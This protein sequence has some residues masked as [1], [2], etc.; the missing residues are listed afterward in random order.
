[1]FLNRNTPSVRE[2]RVLGG[3]WALTL[4][5]AACV[6][7]S[8]VALGQNTNATIRGLVVDPSGA[9]VPTTFTSPNGPL[10]VTERGTTATFATS[11]NF[12]KIT[13]MQ[14][15]RQMQASARFFF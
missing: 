3:V 6:L 7:M 8:G 14:P 9:V 5:L 10:A 13:G 4:V 15:N 12:G 11:S 1:M 2:G